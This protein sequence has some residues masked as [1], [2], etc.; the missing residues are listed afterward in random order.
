MAAI[1]STQSTITITDTKGQVL[2]TQVDPELFAK[3]TDI[4][5]SSTIKTEFDVT[6]MKE[7]LAFALGTIKY[8]E[9]PM[10]TYDFLLIADSFNMKSVTKE[11]M[12]LLECVPVCTAADILRL[13]SNTMKADIKQILTNIVKQHVGM[14][15]TKK[16][17]KYL[18]QETLLMVLSS[19]DYV[20]SPFITSSGVDLEATLLIVI[21]EY[22]KLNYPT[23]TP[24]ST[25]LFKTCLNYIRYDA[26][27][28]KQIFGEIMDNNHYPSVRDVFGARFAE[29]MVSKKHADQRYV[30][31]AKSEE[32]RL[33]NI[34][35]AKLLAADIVA[36]K[37]V[38]DKLD[39]KD[40]QD[41]WYCAVIAKA[42]DPAVETKS[43]DG[44]T[45]MTAN[46]FL[47]HFGGWDEKYDE[48]ISFDSMRFAE[49][50]SFTDGVYSDAPRMKKDQQAWE[51]QLNN[52]LCAAFKFSSPPPASIAPA[53]TSPPIKFTFPTSA[54]TTPAA[55]ASASTTPA[56]TASAS[57]TPAT[58]TIPD[59]P[60]MTREKMEQIFEDTMSSISNAKSGSAE[61]AAA[62]SYLSS[63]TSWITGGQRQQ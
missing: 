47:V 12:V 61:Q 2:L 15:M 31:F 62:D 22:F 17:V 48:V 25:E 33:A 56:A 30:I 5:L 18:S 52:F 38:G 43:G 40:F 49:L 24:A 27:T 53:F 14:F 35:K 19:Q 44:K 16:Y 46:T 23:V 11:L 4:K 10:N 58:S 9:N 6:V 26:I 55:T 32:E 51:E 63:F 36:T 34:E 29:A 8:Y 42:Y 13:H 59:A 41:N 28:Y 45:T 60:P 57:T 1:S 54:S 21:D 7:F 39:V 20:L 37:K 3:L 50:G